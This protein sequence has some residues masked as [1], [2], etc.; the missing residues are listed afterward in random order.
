[1]ASYIFDNDPTGRIFAAALA[2]AVPGASRC[3]C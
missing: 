1:M 2:R 3:A